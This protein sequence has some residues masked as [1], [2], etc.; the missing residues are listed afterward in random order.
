MMSS[1][2]SDQ[3]SVI[4]SFEVITKPCSWCKQLNPLEK[5]KAYCEQCSAGMFRECV[6]C[7]L[8]YPDKKFFEKNETLCNACQLK[9][10]KE[11]ERRAAAKQQQ[12]QRCSDAET[13]LSTKRCGQKKKKIADEGDEEEPGSSPK[14]MKQQPTMGYIP[15]YF[16]KNM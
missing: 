13:K 15:V 6:R 10:L 4:Q 8:P 12:Q 7:K 3:S 14:K 5:N 2:D 1:S 9:Y 11:R 16:S